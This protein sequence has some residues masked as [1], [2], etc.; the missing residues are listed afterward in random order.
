MCAQRGYLYLRE[1]WPLMRGVRN[2]DQSCQIEK[3]L[4]QGAQLGIGRPLDPPVYHHT[5]ESI[6][7]FLQP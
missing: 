2:D 7:Y 5:L 3:A 4:F 1:R 6:G